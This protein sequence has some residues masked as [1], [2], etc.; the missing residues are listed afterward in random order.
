MELATG[1]PV[2][3][4]GGRTRILPGCSAVALVTI[5]HASSCLI[6]LCPHLLM[7]IHCICEAAAKVESFA[8]GNDQLLLSFVI[9]KEFHGYNPEWRP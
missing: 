8:V 4:V 2:R 9:S 3:K 1:H 7:I 6:G 5:I